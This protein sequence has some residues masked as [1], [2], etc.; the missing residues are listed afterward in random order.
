MLFQCVG[1]TTFNNVLFFFDADK[2]LYVKIMLIVC[3]L[4]DPFN[5]VLD[6]FNFVLDPFNFVLDPFNFVLDPFN[7]V[8]DPFNFVLDPFNF[9]FPVIGL[10]KL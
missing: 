3:H 4:L 7:F 8:L 9:V 6:P 10:C 2:I 1:Q 5:F